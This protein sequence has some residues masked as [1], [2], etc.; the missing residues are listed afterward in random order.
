MGKLEGDRYL[1]CLGEG[2]DSV[3]QLVSG[4]LSRP[5][6]FPMLVPLTLTPAALAFLIPSGLGTGKLL[7]Y[8]WWEGEGFLGFGPCN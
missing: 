2:Q 3:T 7:W 4:S 8:Y 5:A 6:V 1:P